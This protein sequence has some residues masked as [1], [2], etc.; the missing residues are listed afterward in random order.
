MKRIDNNT[1]ELTSGAEEAARDFF[2]DLLDRGSGI[3][4]AVEETRKK[5]PL[6]N[7]SEEFYAWLGE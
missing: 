2:D 7:L 1:V 5:F 4:E 6:D 3:P